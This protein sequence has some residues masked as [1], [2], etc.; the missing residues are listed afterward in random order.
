MPRATRTSQA[1][2]ASAVEPDESL[3]AFYNSTAAGAG[4]A[5]PPS[6]SSTS[7]NANNHN[8]DPLWTG[9]RSSN[10]RAT[11][12]AG[13]GT[14]TTSNVTDLSVSSASASVNSP[15]QSSHGGSEAS[16]YTTHGVPGVIDEGDEDGQESESEEEDVVV[17][18]RASASASTSRLV[19]RPTRRRP[20]SPTSEEEEEAQAQMNEADNNNNDGNHFNGVYIDP[21]RS[22]TPTISNF[23]SRLLDESEED[24]LM[25]ATNNGGNG[26][27]YNSVLN[28]DV[29][30]LADATNEEVEARAMEEL[31]WDEIGKDK[32]LYTVDLERWKVAAENAGKFK[33][34]GTAEYSEF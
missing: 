34:P 12:A 33:E 16:S 10:R 14:S 2:L 27:T 1:A 19:R 30:D 23:S 25:N 3:R 28:G 8:N 6:S 4:V 7:N 21:E 5:A 18:T 26:T 31:Q 13:L 29:D 22:N 17:I 32:E 24:E 20:P 9:R 11:A 15:I